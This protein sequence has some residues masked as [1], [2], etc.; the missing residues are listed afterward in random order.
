MFLMFPQCSETPT[1]TAPPTHTLFTFNIKINECIN[2]M[3]V[4]VEISWTD[5]LVE[6]LVCSEFRGDVRN[7]CSSAEL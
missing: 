2:S 6:V 1:P 3:Y 7:T 4:I 5:V